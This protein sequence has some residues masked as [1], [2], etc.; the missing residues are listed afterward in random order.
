MNSTPF[1]GAVV[2]C[3]D[4]PGVREVLTRCN[5]PLITYGLDR[6]ADYHARGVTFADGKT[7]FA[8]YGKGER[9]RGAR[10]GR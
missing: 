6:E 7:R 3:I 8:L 2:A 10:R 5:R 9:L 4:E 1:Y